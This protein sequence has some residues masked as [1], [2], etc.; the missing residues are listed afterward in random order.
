[1][2]LC[3][4]GC[5]EDAGVYATPT[6][7]SGKNVSGKPK[8]FIQY[9][10]VKLLRK[11]T[12]ETETHCARGHLKSEFMT[13]HGKCLACHRIVDA[14]WKRDNPVPRLAYLRRWLYGITDEQYQA[15]L[16]KQDR[17]CS[18]CKV[19]FSGGKGNRD[20]DSPC[21]DHDHT[22]C[23]KGK[24]CGKCIRGLICRKCNIMLG[25]A[26]DNV[27]TLSNAIQYLNK[28][29]ETQCNQNLSSELNQTVQTATA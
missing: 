4:C 2:A 28:F 15:M 21:V 14:R 7:R 5:G 13:V 22:C 16:I 18:I 23:P 12:G 11:R 6:Y 20:K 27:E 24:S 10:T 29:K 9:H 8:R 19:L 26:Q 1:M 25:N 3:E 17:K